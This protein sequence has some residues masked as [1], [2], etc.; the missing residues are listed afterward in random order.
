MKQLLLLTVLL[1]SGLGCVRRPE[2]VPATSPAVVMPTFS[3]RDLPATFTP[4]AT[5][6]GL[7]P[8]PLATATPVGPTPTPIDFTQTAVELR[9]LI[10]ALNLERRLQGNIAS[11]IIFV[12]ETGGRALQRSN[13][14][15]VL[16]DLQQ[17]LP[18]LALTPLP[19]GCDRC[20]YVAYALPLAGQTGAGW[21][22][23]PVLLA[24]V[25]NIM[26]AVLGAHVPLGT[27]VG[28]RRSAS[29]YAPAHTI[30]VTTA[31]AVWLWLATEPEIDDPLAV[32]A[33]LP[34]LDAILNQL[35]PETLN[36][37]YVTSC[38]GAPLE[39][40]YLDVAG[41]TRQIQISCPEFT[42]PTTLL[43]LYVALDNALQD[44]LADVAGPEKPPSGFPLTAV[45]NYRRQ[46]GAQLTLYADGLAVAQDALTNVYTNTLTTAAVI[47]LT[48]QLV[49]SGLVK[50][51]LATFFTD[52]ADT[53]ASSRLL[54]RGP[55]GVYDARWNG[56]QTAVAALDALLD[57]FILV[58]DAATAAPTPED[59]PVPTPTP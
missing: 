49:D 35:S 53:A 37:D 56:V 38:P 18:T 23:D 55:D 36:S 20:V 21:L 41:V 27:V 15:R 51:G 44:K 17:V 50:P 34:N 8:T 47:S 24:S 42:L 28:L 7:T 26:A 3:T 4:A 59:T 2:A 57:T 6:L 12:D 9:Y 46:D 19:E 22:Q 39:T 31:G 43:P 11:Q 30:A 25:E 40:L 54:V 33:T 1:L 48:T 58:D 16:L 13:Q 14:A 10:P 29:P 52:A 45:L 5:V 32:A